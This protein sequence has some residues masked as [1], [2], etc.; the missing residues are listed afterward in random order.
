MNRSI[1]AGMD[2]AEMGESFDGEYE[3]YRPLQNGNIELD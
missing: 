2:E 1:K 3:E